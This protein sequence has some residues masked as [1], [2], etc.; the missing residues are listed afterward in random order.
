[1]EHEEAARRIKELSRELE[2]H[3]HRY[4]VLAAPVISDKAFDDMLKELERLEAR[5][6][7]LA[8]PNSPTQRVGG[9]ITK[10]FP[11]VAH[12]Y[13]M[14]S[15]SNSYSRDDVADFVA[16]VEKAV[17]RA[18]SVLELKYDGVALRLTYENGRLVR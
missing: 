9:D 17:G 7:D 4:Y 8:D 11:T 2:F 1:M 3:N 18:T 10:A 5:F 6:P 15:L 13:P 14:L 16:R 12:R